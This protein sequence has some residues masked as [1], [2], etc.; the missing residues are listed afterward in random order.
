MN[1]CGIELPAL[2]EIRMCSFITSVSLGF[3]ASLIGMGFHCLS[4]R[5][6]GHCS[7]LSPLKKSSLIVELKRIFSE[8]TVSILHFS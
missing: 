5:S 6:V 7:G 4:N 1:S 8:N 3:T 2:V